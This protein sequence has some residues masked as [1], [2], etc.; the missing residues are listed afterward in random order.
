MG[1]GWHARPERRDGGQEDHFDLI[2][3]LSGEQPGDMRHTEENV[4]I[5]VLIEK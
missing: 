1:L 5:H 2:S 4:D 3:I